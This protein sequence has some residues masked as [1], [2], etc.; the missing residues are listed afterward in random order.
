MVG[1]LR[2]YIMLNWRYHRYL[3]GFGIGLIGALLY[4]WDKC[5]DSNVFDYF[6]NIQTH[7]INWMIVV[8]MFLSLIAYNFG[9]KADEM[10]MLPVGA[11]TKL[12]AGYVAG[13]LMPLV[14]VWIGAN[15]MLMLLGQADTYI[16]N[17]HTVIY[18]ISRHSGYGYFKAMEGGVPEKEQ[19]MNKIYN[20]AVSIALYASSLWFVVIGV[21]TWGLVKKLTIGV[22][23][24]LMMFAALIGTMYLIEEVIGLKMTPDHGL[25]IFWIMAIPTCLAAVFAYAAYRV[26]RNRQIKG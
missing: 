9:G 22:F 16:F 14:F 26:L 5:G 3:I 24:Y 20:L 1:A 8:A 13:V 12:A 21:T 4:I 15:V 10:Q 25:R 2:Y 19:Y 11:A 23:V 18:D 7:G 17:P 6:E